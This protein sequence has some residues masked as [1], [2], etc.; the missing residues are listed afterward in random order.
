MF[1]VEEEVFLCWEE[2]EYC[3]FVSNVEVDVG[4]CVYVGVSDYGFYCEEWECLDWY[5]F[6]YVEDCYQQGYD[7]VD[8]EF[9]NLGYQ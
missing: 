2:E 9:W 3:I 1:F 4:N 5:E 6:I 7:V 8:V